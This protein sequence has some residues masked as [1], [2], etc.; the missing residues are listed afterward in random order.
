M[1]GQI[2]KFPDQGRPAFNA[3]LD[4]MAADLLPDPVAIAVS[5]ADLTPDDTIAAEHAL[6]RE[7]FPDS[8]SV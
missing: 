1:T 5:P 2:I 8:G 3:I 7:I 6:L 4:A